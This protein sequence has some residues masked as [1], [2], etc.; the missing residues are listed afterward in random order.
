MEREPGQRVQKHTEVPRQVSSADNLLRMGVSEKLLSEQK[1]SGS[2]EHSGNPFSAFGH[3]L[4][5]LF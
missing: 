5:P 3:T 1:G 4:R 2:C